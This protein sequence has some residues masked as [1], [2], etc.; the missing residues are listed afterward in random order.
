MKFKLSCVIVC[1]ENNPGLYWTIVCTLLD[2]QQPK[3]VQFLN[4]GWYYVILDAL[5]D[6]THFIIED[7][8][9]RRQKKDEG[10]ESLNLV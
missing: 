3:F 2:Y 4:V 9:A 8:I 10:L 1:G 7:G 6:T 5:K